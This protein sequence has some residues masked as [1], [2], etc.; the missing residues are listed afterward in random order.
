MEM[1]NTSWTRNMAFWM[2]FRLDRVDGCDRLQEEELTQGMRM[3]ILMM[4]T[5]WLD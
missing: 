3:D 2:R 4:R 1:E 5:L